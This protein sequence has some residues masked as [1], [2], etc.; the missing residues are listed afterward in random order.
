MKFSEERIK[1]LKTILE[2]DYGQDVSKEVASDLGES[3]LRL[4]RVVLN[5]AEKRKNIEMER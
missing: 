5:H 3:L 2:R 4:T 1:E